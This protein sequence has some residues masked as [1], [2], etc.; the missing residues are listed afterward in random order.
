MRKALKSDNPYV[1]YTA[2]KAFRFLGKVDDATPT[3]KELAKVYT[4]HYTVLAMQ[5]L[6]R[7]GHK[8][9]LGTLIDLLGQ[10]EDL[11]NSENPNAESTQMLILAV[12]ERETGTYK[13]TGNE[14]SKWWNGNS[15]AKSVPE[16]PRY[17][18]PH[19]GALQP[20]R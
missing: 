13:T 15:G 9:Y 7:A 1:R 6:V 10:I 20:R 16:A 12:L 3:L 4:H 19:P 5:E 8:E 14:W 18:D 2:A 11:G 17:A